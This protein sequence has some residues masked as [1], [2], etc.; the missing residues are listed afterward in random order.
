[1]TRETRRHKLWRLRRCVDSRA[2]LK[3]APSLVPR[4]IACLRAK[5]VAVNLDNIRADADIHLQ[6]LEMQQ[7]V[8]DARFAAALGLN[9]E[10]L[11]GPLEPRPPF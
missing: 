2:A 10:G 1:M 5:Q 11:A 7:Q 6:Y 3:T 9:T 4:G 8:A